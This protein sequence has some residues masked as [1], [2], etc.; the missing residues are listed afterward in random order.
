MTVDAKLQEL[1]DGMEPTLPDKHYR[2]LQ[3]VFES[4]R[5]I[6]ELVS[7]KNMTMDRLRERLWGG[8]QRAGDAPTDPDV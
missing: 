6:A 5:Y 3:A 4:Y 7:D 2:T 8:E 1:L